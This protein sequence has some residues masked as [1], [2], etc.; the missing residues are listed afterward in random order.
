MCGKLFSALT[1]RN[2]GFSVAGM[3]KV[4]HKA[5]LHGVFLV[6]TRREL[7]RHL[8]ISEQ[9]VGQW[10]RVPIHQVF[11]VERITGIPRERLRPDIYDAPRPRHRPP[12]R[13]GMARASVG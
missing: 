9:A 6:I 1:A 10:R 3:P 8:G 7:S 13:A 5:I 11:Q 12:K 2:G 4:D